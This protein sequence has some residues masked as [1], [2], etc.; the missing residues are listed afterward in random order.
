M[1]TPTGEDKKNGGRVRILIDVDG[2]LLDFVGAC[3]DRLDRDKKEVFNRLRYERLDEVFHNWESLSA[4]VSR[5]DFHDRMHWLKD[6]RGMLDNL[7][8][9]GHKLVALTAPWVSSP[10]WCHDRIKKLEPAGFSPKE[11][12]F[13]PQGQKKFVDGDV[14]IEDTLQ[15]AIDWRVMRAEG[16][17]ELAIVVE[18]PWNERHRHKLAREFNV[19]HCPIYEVS[20]KVYSLEQRL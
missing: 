19:V 13:C 5:I 12:I 16:G 7:R 4:V 10:T 20:R 15:T 6:A 18:Q 2:V 3:C 9:Q 8:G 1:A 17:N 11:I 14:L